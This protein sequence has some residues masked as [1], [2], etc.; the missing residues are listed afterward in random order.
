MSPEAVSPVAGHC[1]VQCFSII[2]HY[3]GLSQQCIFSIYSCDLHLLWRNKKGLYRRWWSFSLVCKSYNLEYVYERRNTGHNFISS[4]SRKISAYTCECRLLK[5]SEMVPERGCLRG[6]AKQ[7]LHV[8]GSDSEFCFEY[9]A[10]LSSPFTSLWVF[11][12]PF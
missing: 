8:S 1:Y 10:C 3:L 12:Q 7:E 11:H 4:L 5:S 9:R 2:L 6:T